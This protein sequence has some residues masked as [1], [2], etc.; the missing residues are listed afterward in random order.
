ME[1]DGLTYFR[2]HYLNNPEDAKDPLAS[3]LLAED[4]SDLPPA[5]IITA[6]Y[7]PLRDEGGGIC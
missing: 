7:D 1:K 4:F 3:P 5:T 6:E 2:D